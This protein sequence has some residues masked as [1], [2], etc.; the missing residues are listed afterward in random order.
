MVQTE[1]ESALPPVQDWDSLVSGL[2]PNL[3]ETASIRLGQELELT[4]AGT[5][6]SGEY[7]P[8]GPGLFISLSV[9]GQLN[10]SV[11][12]PLEFNLAYNLAQASFGQPD[13]PEFDE[14][15]PLDEA[16]AQA[17]EDLVAILAQT[18][19]DQLVQEHSSQLELAVSDRDQLPESAQDQPGFLTLP[20][21]KVAVDISIDHTPVGQ[22]VLLV[23]SALFQDDD[24]DLDQDEDNYHIAPDEMA[25]LVQPGQSEEEEQD[26]EE[27]VQDGL[28]QEADLANYSPEIPTWPEDESAQ[29][30][31][32]TTPE[33]PEEESQATGSEEEQTTAEET[34]TSPTVDINTLHTTLLQG[35]YQVEE[36]LGALLGETFEL[37]E[38]ISRVVSKKDFLNQFQNKIVIT[39][40]AVSGDH[41]GTVYS[42][43]TLADAISLGG[44]LIMLPQDEIAS[45][46]KSGQLKE[47]EEDAFGEVINILTGAYSHAFGE[48]FP[49]KLRL[50]KDRMTSTAP[51]KVDIS[52]DEPF[53]DGE[54]FLA[55]YRMRLGS[56]NLEQMNILIPPNL[57]SMSMQDVETLKKQPSTGA[58]GQGGG[59]GTIFIPGQEGSSGTPAIVVISEDNQ[60]GQVVS[61][62]LEDEGVELIQLKLRDKMRERLKSHN[63]LGAFLILKN[64]DDN[65]LGTLIK[66]RSV[67]KG[68]CPLIIGGPKWTRTKVIQ[69]IRYGAQDILTT[70][71][72]P[73]Q[74]VDKAHKHMFAAAV[75]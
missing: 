7:R 59:T 61:T 64:I 13:S 8:S 54:Y 6:A 55:S 19:K 35:S 48:Y 73:A 21:W 20:S 14:T 74:I 16:R 33:Q 39:N 12:V 70:P 26:S 66:V 58:T 11:H 17:V 56:Q 57:V 23:P 4:Y 47:D 75:H 52:S 18:A 31:E 71:P 53:P 22:A 2:L 34:E 3:A 60:Q 51:T 10:G 49:H 68:R 44:K 30:E 5:E 25:A 41:Y 38:Y 32:G 46:I 40:L 27:G 43:L 65:S 63:V 37:Y 29:P 42:V 69:A 50:K 36:E 45:K 62:S 1:P 24:L 28:N 67:L 9:G 15:K 72:D